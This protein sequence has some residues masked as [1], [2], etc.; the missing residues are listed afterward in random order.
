MKVF[1][2][3]IFMLYSACVFCQSTN[4]PLIQPKNGETLKDSE[5]YV[6]E[7]FQCIKNQAIKYV[8]TEKNVES[9]AK[10]AVVSCEAYIPKI[11]NSNVYWL[12][13]SPKGKRE[14]TERI[15]SD[16]ERLATKFAMDEKLK[17]K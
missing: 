4:S 16:G 14:F 11:A 5:K 1:L 10:A 6:K 3:A 2:T 8:K 12:N 17:S 13:S 15:E 9:I 7:Y